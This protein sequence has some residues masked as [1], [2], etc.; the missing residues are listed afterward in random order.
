VALAALGFAG[1]ELYLLYPAV[2]GVLGL[3]QPL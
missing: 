2:R 3:F 1:W